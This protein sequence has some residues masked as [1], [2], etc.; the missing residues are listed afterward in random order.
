MSA[1]DLWGKSLLCVLAFAVGDGGAGL[2]VGFAAA[3]GFALV[4][5]LFALGHGQFALDLST[6]E[7][8]ASGDERMSFDLRL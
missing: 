1:P 2:T 5:V 7:I 4:P 6:P 3:F 8:E